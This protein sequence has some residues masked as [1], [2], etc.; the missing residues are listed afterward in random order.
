M[1]TKEDIERMEK[2]GER[3]LKHEEYLELYC[4]NQVCTRFPFPISAQLSPTYR[5]R[6]L[7]PTE[8]TKAKFP[9]SSSPPP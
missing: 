7:V 5:T 9:S 8:K 1:P 6:P 2:S 4:N 3:M